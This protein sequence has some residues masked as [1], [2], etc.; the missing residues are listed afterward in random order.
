MGAAS[1][2]PKEDTLEEKRYFL[3]QTAEDV[4]TH[5]GDDDINSALDWFD[6][7]PKMGTEDF[8]DRLFGRY[9]GPTF[10]GEGY[11]EVDLDQLDNQAAK[12]LM[13]RARKLR[14]ERDL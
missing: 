7:E 14:K 8:L 5:V 3:L 13:A 9:G 10:K 4:D 1:V 6:G 2:N 12:R 11:D